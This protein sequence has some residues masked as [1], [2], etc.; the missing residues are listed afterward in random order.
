MASNDGGIRIIKKLKIDNALA[1]HQF[2]S[3]F[4]LSNACK[5]TRSYVERCFTV[6]VETENFLEL[7][8]ALLLK[9]LA[10]SE[11]FIT[12]EREVLDATIKWLRYDFEGRGEF[13][14]KLL[15]KV[16][17][18]LL[19]NKM[20]ERLESSSPSKADE[21]NKFNEMLREAYE[22]NATADRNSRYC[23]QNSFQVLVCGGMP[24]HDHLTE[25][26]PDAY[27]RQLSLSDLNLEADVLP[28]MKS[29][30]RLFE[31]VWSKGDVYVFGGVPSG[32]GGVKRVEKYSQATG[33]WTDVAVMADRRQRFCAC[34]FAD[35]I[36][37]F[38][39]N[40]EDCCSTDF[41]NLG[42]S[43]LEFDTKSR[44]FEEKARMQWLKFEAACAVFNERLVVCGGNNFGGFFGTR[45][46]ESYDVTR[47]EWTE[48]ADM[49]SPR[50]R[51]SAVVVG[52]KLFAVG[53]GY[54]YIPCEVY[55]SQSESF[56]GLT[57]KWPEKWPCE[58]CDALAVGR[59]IFV[60][61]KLYSVV[62]VYDV[63]K[64]EWSR[65]AC[66]EIRG[67]RRGFSC[68]KLP[69]LDKKN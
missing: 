4:N 61:D 49:T 58:V 55:D 63:D 20:P 39:G 51:H 36:F 62:D 14:S 17:L 68:V 30:R 42:R 67:K 38:G 1:F 6:L 54:G 66:K 2:A 22:R 11:L 48:M 46:V 3:V 8:F 52:S 56:V 15:Q 47:N 21:N 9:I 57:G 37:I 5:A 41:E 60:F 10:S 34:A 64:D 18:H 13:G 33:R 50:H 28:P 59:K 35:K 26:Y 69:I 32:H 45:C 43:C 29:E 23:S 19:F 24:N 16:R 12:S 7:N 25:T 53:G 40:D 31:A 27:A 65:E 44:R